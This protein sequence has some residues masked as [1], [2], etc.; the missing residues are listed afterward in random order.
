[1]M[2]LALPKGRNLGVTLSAF[3]AAGIGLAGL[4][5]N[6][7]RLR[8]SFEVDA[9]EVLLLKDWDVPLYVEYGVAD[10]GVVGSDVLAERDSDVLVPARL[11]EGGCRLSLIGPE[12]SF[13]EAGSQVRLATK[14]PGL[15]RRLVASRSWGAEIVKLS[16]S[17]ELGP[18]LQLSDVALDIVQTGATLRENQLVE[19][20]VV[21]DVYPCL[22]VNRASYQRYRS[23]INELVR[24]LEEQELVLL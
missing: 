17:V 18:L 13:P 1:M 2:R 10:F 4:E 21:E 23:R 11:S 22:I 24:R 14:Y 12:G 19:L 8:G 6:G 16:G 3:R 7:R 15:A 5:E 20:E 9:L